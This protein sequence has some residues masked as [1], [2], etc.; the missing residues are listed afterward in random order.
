VQSR[1]VGTSLKHFAAN[2]QETD[3][4][5]VSAEVDERTLREI[6]LPA[7]EHVVATAQPWTV[8]CS[9]NKINGVYASEDHWLLTEVLRD[10]WG[11][12][13]LVV[14]DWGAVNERDLAVA[15]GLDLEMPSSS[16]TGARTIVAAAANGTLDEA[17]VDRAAGRIAVIGELAR[18]PRY[19][20]AGSSQVC[21]TRLDDALSALTQAVA[22]ARPVSFAAGYV[23][24]S[25]SADLA[26]PRPGGPGGMAPGP[27]RRISRRR[28]PPRG[29]QPRGE[30]GRD[31]AAATGRQPHR[32]SLPL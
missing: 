32:R 23:V 13:G 22:G 27:G 19:Q 26:G 14:S 20:G 28:H 8:M 12:D 5:T 2:N 6:Y 29:R 15:G 3:R 31:P 1:G 21:P 25:E 7:F 11:Y 10:E 24:E 4:M 9:Y 16:G 18:T 17:D 30:D